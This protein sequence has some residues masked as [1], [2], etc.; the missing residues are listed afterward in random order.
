VS[1]LAL[2]ALRA[3]SPMVFNICQKAEIQQST[4]IYQVKKIVK[5]LGIS[6]FTTLGKSKELICNVLEKIIGIHK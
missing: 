6:G 5:E 2:I 1:A 4:V 3:D